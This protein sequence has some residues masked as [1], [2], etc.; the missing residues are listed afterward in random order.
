MSR[1]NDSVPATI[2]VVG[3]GTASAPPDRC[4][5]DVG[6]EVTRK[7]VMDASAQANG[8]AR[9]LL[10]ALEASGVNRLDI[11]SNRLSLQPE[12][13]HR[14]DRQTP[15]GYT[16]RHSYTAVVR[17]IEQ[18]PAVIDAAVR[19]AGEAATV[20]GIN[21]G[22]ED[23]APLERRARHEAFNNAHDKARQLAELA[24]VELGSAVSIT[25]MRTGSGP[26]PPGTMRMRAF[27]AAESAGPP[28]AFGD[29]EVM[30]NLNVEFAI[31]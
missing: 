12:Y 23:S 25:E 29:Q 18:A 4:E 3:T 5:I 1:H 15:I 28:L 14:S 2:A 7:T 6:V 20:E 26:P 17:D 10:E 24:G 8:A 16:A 27:M 21:F 22:H 31:V 30:V 19:A 11:R 13:D 9:L